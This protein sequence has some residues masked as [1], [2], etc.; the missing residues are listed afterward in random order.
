M[1]VSY[2]VYPNEKDNDNPEVFTG[3]ACFASLINRYSSTWARLNVYNAHRVVYHCKPYSLTQEQ[4]E[5]YCRFLR[6]VLDRKAVTLKM[7]PG[8]IVDATVVI[9]KGNYGKTLVPLTAI[10]YMEEHNA[11]VKLFI[12]IMDDNPKA[13]AAKLFKLFIELNIAKEGVYGGGH[14]LTQT[15]GMPNKKAISLI[16]FRQNMKDYKRTSCNFHFRR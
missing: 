5:K 13:G 15:Y 16:Q 6:M 4:V 2:T 8:A 1:S 3:A 7:S 9:Y 14:Y 12:K 11:L 10:R